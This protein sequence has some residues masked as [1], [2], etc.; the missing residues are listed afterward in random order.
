MAGLS[1][2]GSGRNGVNE[3]IQKEARQCMVIQVRA[4]QNVNSRTDEMIES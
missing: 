4:A 2:G 3:R 1:Y